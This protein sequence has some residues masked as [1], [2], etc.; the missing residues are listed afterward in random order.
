MNCTNSGI[1]QAPYNSNTFNIF[2]K[3]IAIL[4]L[5]YYYELQSHMKMWLQ[6]YF[7]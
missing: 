3:Q 4:S 2:L 7:L 1:W 6:W 5:Y